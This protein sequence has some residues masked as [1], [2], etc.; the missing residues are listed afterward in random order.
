MTKKTVNEATHLRFDM[1]AEIPPD[2]SQNSP[3]RGISESD[4]PPHNSRRMPAAITLAN[5]S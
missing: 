1:I 3:Y 5:S 2:I 4:V